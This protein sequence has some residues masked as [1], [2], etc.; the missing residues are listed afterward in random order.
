MIIMINEA[1]II[2][3]DLH[4]SWIHKHTRFQR[5]MNCLKFF[6]EVFH[7]LFQILNC[8]KILVSLAVLCFL[9]Y[10]ITTALSLFRTK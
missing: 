2:G 6:D 3:L 4:F 7:K 10:Y 9:V 1:V 8:L 5:D